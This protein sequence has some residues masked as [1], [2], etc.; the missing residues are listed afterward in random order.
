MTPKPKQAVAASKAE[1]AWRKLD[2]YASRCSGNLVQAK[3]EVYLAILFNAYRNVPRSRIREA[4]EQVK[5]LPAP[6]K[7]EN[8]IP[9]LERMAAL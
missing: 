8:I 2:A 9:V 4:W 7:A 3:Q 1:R 5:A 6:R